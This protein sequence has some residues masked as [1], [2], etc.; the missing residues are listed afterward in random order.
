MRVGLPTNYD[1]S[2]SP[3]AKRS[4]ERASD[5]DGPVEMANM[6]APPRMKLPSKDYIER[7]LQNQCDL[8][9]KTTAPNSATRILS[10]M[11]KAPSTMS[12][13]TLPK[14]KAPS[15]ESR[16]TRRVPS[17]GAEMIKPSPPSPSMGYGRAVVLGKTAREYPNPSSQKPAEPKPAEPAPKSKNTR[18][19]WPAAAVGSAQTLLHGAVM[20]TTSKLFDI[21]FT[22]FI[23]RL[24]AQP[25]CHDFLQDLYSQGEWSAALPVCPTEAGSAALFWYATVWVVPIATAVRCFANWTGILKIHFFEDLPTIL[26]MLVGWA[27]GAAFT[28]HLHELESSYASEL[29]QN[30][31]MCNAFRLCY[32]AVVSLCCAFVITVVAPLAKNVEFGS[33]RLVD[34]IEDFL[35]LIFAM[36]HRGASVTVMLIWYYAIQ[37]TGPRAE[38]ITCSD[39][40]IRLHFFWACTANMLGAQISR[41]LEQKEDLA[42]ERAK[43]A[44]EPLSVWTSGLILIS[45][46]VQTILGF[47]AANSWLLF[48]RLVPP[49]NIYMTHAPT[50]S[51]MLENFG[52]GLFL[53]AMGLLYVYVTG[54]SKP[55]GKFSTLSFTLSSM[56]FTL[57]NVWVNMSIKAY[58]Q[59]AVRLGIVPGPKV[60]ANPNP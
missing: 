5:I 14:P 7:I 9:S 17:Y 19:I 8:P 13:P 34:M 16:P 55:E 49:F 24:H 58:A 28:K 2:V 35:E 11:P 32:C 54:E 44:G 59:L 12:R 27:F 50:V 20:F 21:L 41:F 45:D 10:P 31:D 30:D 23:A 1:A 26:N 56:S 53:F 6:P 38:Q 18:C 37:E 48:I 47:T 52:V 33:G 3:D 42:R 29:C 57:G 4:A 40:D 25:F 36:V 39:T 43:K 15:T 60:T 22:A 46:L 51:G